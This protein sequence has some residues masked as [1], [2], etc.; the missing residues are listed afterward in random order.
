MENRNYIVYVHKNKLNGK[1]YFGI[2]RQNIEDRWRKN[3]KGYL[4]SC[5]TVFGRAV[6]KYGWDNFTH[7]I[8]YRNFT[9][10]EAVWK[11]RFLIKIFHTY[12]HDPKCNGY[13]MTLGGEGTTGSKHSAETRRKMSMAQKAR[14]NYPSPSVET[15]KKLSLALKGRPSPNKGKRLSED[16]KYKMTEARKGQKR[17]EAFK[18]A[19]SERMSNGKSVCCKA[20]VQFDLKG[21]QVNEFYSLTHAAETVKGDR[22]SIARCC[23]GKQATSKG[24]RWEYKDNYLERNTVRK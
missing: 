19:A 24:Y 14:T 22:S 18:K 9:E 1:M 10:E 12:V 23:K 3:G 11:E 4:Y 13:N 2:T 20:V 7:K 16:T 15:R 6:K 8:L 21:N 5:D 17:T